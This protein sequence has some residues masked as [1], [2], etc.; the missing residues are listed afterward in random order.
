MEEYDLENVTIITRL[1]VGNGTTDC[2]DLIR[3]AEA[4]D[5]GVGKILA[6]RLSSN[7]F[8]GWESAFVVMV[9]NQY[10]G[11]CLLEK[12]DDYGTG[13]DFSSVTP[14]ITAVYVNPQFRGRHMSEKLIDAACDYARSLG[15]DAVYLISSHEGFYEKYGFG[16]FT[17]TLTTTGS[18]E[19]VYRKSISD[20]K[21]KNDV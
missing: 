10:A 11:L 19:A 5:W 9:D 6:K 3:W 15:F 12:K 20:T 18:T 16:L 17:Q 14:F 4:W 8:S 13:I 1:P 21:R 2:S 7:V